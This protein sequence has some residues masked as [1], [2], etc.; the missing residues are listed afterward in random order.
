MT[1]TL[2]SESEFLEL[3]AKVVAKAK[4]LL[5]ETNKTCGKNWPA[6]SKWEDL[7]GTSKSI[8]MFSAREALLIDDKHF[9]EIVRNWPY[10]D[11]GQAFVDKQFGC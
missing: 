10:S 2:M 1:E 6:G 3:Y 8:F 7:V 4:Q 5:E 9:L 11:E